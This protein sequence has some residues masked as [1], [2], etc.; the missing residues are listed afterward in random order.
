MQTFG[1]TH[2]MPQLETDDQ[3][4]HGSTDVLKAFELEYV[5]E[6]FVVAIGTQKESFFDFSYSSSQFTI[7][8]WQ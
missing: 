1:L 2:K 8:Q 7:E 4:F 6:V 5:S 3:P